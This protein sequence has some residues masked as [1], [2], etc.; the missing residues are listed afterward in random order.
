MGQQMVGHWAEMHCMCLCL[1]MTASHHS[2]TQGSVVEGR[3]GAQCVVVAIHKADV[4]TVGLRCAGRL[5]IDDGCREGAQRSVG[6]IARRIDV[7]AED[8][9]VEPDLSY[10]R[11]RS[12]WQCWIKC[13]RCAAA[14]EPGF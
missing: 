6:G 14:W 5:N 3:S 10:M 1:G 4:A 2:A 8:L 13:K 11:P 12:Q 7:E 9:S